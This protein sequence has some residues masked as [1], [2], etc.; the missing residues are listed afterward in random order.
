[1]FNHTGKHKP[2]QACLEIGPKKRHPL[3]TSKTS[4][5]ETKTVMKGSR[6]RMRKDVGVRAGEVT[7][8][9]DVVSH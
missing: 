6:Q 4:S 5:L 2:Q 3:N 1:M 9:C 8:Q 7:E